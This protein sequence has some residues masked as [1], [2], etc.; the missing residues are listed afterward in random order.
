MEKFVDTDPK[1]VNTLLH[2]F[3]SITGI[4]ICGFGN[5]LL[6]DTLIGIL[7][8][9]K[10]ANKYCGII[11]NGTFLKEKLP[12]LI[13]WYQPNYVS[14]SLNA[15]TK[16]LH[17]KI[18]NTDKWDEVIDGIKACVE[19]PIDCWVSSVVTTENLK[20][21]P[22][23]I[24]LVHSLGVKT[25]HFHNVL[26]HFDNKIEDK[27]FWDLCLQDHHQS[28]IDEFVKIP[29]AAI[30][31]KWPTLINKSGGNGACEFPWKSI[32]VDGNGS[33]SICNSVLP[34]KA[35]NGNINDNVV[36]NNNYCTKFRDDY[37]SNSNE[38]PCSK[39]FRNFQWY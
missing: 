9:I 34:C 28:I 18:S 38:L 29:E 5:P 16:E 19:S 2:R 20:F 30:V 33:I 23:I 22:D 13:G 39:C 21:I 1:I 11:T 8:A 26:P 17:R 3:P 27:S 10:R 6:S 15:H 31:K 4:C 35:K 7:E 37:M 12:R 14:V 32:A 24:K 36:F 25:L